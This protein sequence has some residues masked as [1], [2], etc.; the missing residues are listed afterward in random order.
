MTNKC[1][2]LK[3]YNFCT[4][5][6]KTKALRKKVKCRYENPFD[7]PYLEEYLSKQTK[8]QQRALKRFLNDSTGDMNA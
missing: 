3:N 1:P 2:F 4:H 6:G 5:N 8:S 7:C